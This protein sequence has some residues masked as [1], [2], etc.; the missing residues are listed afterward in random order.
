MSRRVQT[1]WAV[2]TSAMIA[3]TGCAPSQPFYFNED[4]DLSHYVDTATNIEYP[5]TQV[6]TLDEVKGAQA[7]FT[8]DNTKP[9]EMWDLTLEEAMQITLINS[10]VMR[11]LGGRFASTAQIQP[12]VGGAPET[13]ISSRGATGVNANVQTIYDA[14][15]TESTPLQSGIGGNVGVEAALSLFDAS[16]VTQAVWQKNDRPQN[17]RGAA[18][19]FFTPAFQQDTTGWNSELSKVTATGGRF[20]FS[21]NTVYDQNNNPTRQVPSDWN[22]NFE[23]AFSQPLLAGAG[24]QFNRIAGPLFGFNGP[25]G[26]AG[27]LNQNQNVQFRGVMLARINTDISLAGFEAG[28]RNMVADVENAYWD[29]YFDYRNLEA[30][31]AARASALQTWKKIHALYVVGARGGE[32]EK[33]AQSREQYFFFRSQV[34]TALNNVYREENR[35]RYMMGLTVNDGRL[36]RPADEPTTA[37]V[38]FEWNEIHCEALARSVE[39]RQQKWRVKSDELVLIA[40]KNLLLPRLDAIGRYRFLGL[41]D[42]WLDPDRDRSNGQL[43]GTNAFQSLT[44]GDFQEWQLGV[45]L[46]VP[47][48]LRNQLSGVRNAQ[49][50][51][52]RD[53]A[54]LQDQELELSHELADAVRNLEGNY[55]LSQ[56]NFN[57]R[58]AAERQVE[59]VQAAFEAETVTL[60]LLLD[61]QRRRADAE[62]AYY[63]SLTDY[64]RSVSQIHFRKGSLLE[65]NG[66]YLAEGP[67]PAKAQFDAYRLARQRDASYY[68]DYGYTRPRVISQGPYEQHADGHG[69]AEGEVFEGEMTP[70]EG[71]PHMAPPEEL[72]APAPASARGIRG[73]QHSAVIRGS[74]DER[75]SEGPVLRQPKLRAAAAAKGGQ[76]DWGDLGIDGRGVEG[77]KQPKLAKAPVTESQSRPES[78]PPKRTVLKQAKPAVEPASATE[79]AEAPAQVERAKFEWKSS[80]KNEPHADSETGATHRAAAGWK[81]TKS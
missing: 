31:K 16:F 17:V 69:Q 77:S 39:L 24:V 23:F 79:P 14:A 59:A 44:T 9:Q 13:L 65:Y 78:G 71:V 62:V 18:A 3:L 56:S 72:P 4:G 20:A 74:E 28:V 27:N 52:A 29:L 26:L 34:Q 61:A 5:D 48:G 33:E 36:I 55:T 75:G 57:R 19:N 80:T 64:N 76:F 7:P 2:F 50:T 81:G 42:D 1:V 22:Q 47:I 67:W 51:L 63:R 21:A 15:I 54:V 25:G 49:L 40:A 35:L 11:S 45:Q 30:T 41:G 10:K 37:K 38:S 43:A 68:L 12:P 46:S 6:E 8:L 66:V 53:R 32:A 70:A 60:D 73:G 58:V